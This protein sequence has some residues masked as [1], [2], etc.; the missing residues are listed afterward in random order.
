[1]FPSFLA[2]AGQYHLLQ[3]LENKNRPPLWTFIYN[4]MLWVDVTDQR[5]EGTVPKNSDSAENFRA[6]DL[7]VVLPKNIW[8]S[9][10]PIINENQPLHLTQ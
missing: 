6:S 2:F 9:R 10:V 7:W 8:D 4:K 1:M 5:E 3:A